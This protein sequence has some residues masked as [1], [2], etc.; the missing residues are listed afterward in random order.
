MA[1]PAQN[2]SAQTTNRRFR[3]GAAALS[4]AT[5]A[6][7]GLSACG[8]QNTSASAPA[9]TATATAKASSTADAAVKCGQRQG[10]RQGKRRSL[11]ER[12]RK[13]LPGHRHRHRK[14]CDRQRC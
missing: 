8:A 9:P 11:P 1:R 14:R 2:T 6:A 7:L 5:I 13:Q 3:T 4:L 12:H 10:H